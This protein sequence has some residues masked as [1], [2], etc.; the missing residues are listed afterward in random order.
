MAMLRSYLIGATYDWLNDH[1]FTPYILVDTEYD[2]VEV[3]WDFVDDDGKIVL[4]L[5][6]GAIRDFSC[7][8]EGINF[9]A[10]FGGEPMDVFIPIE[11]VLSLYS[12]ESSQGIYAR[13]DVYGLIVNEGDSDV[14][15]D[16]PSLEDKKNTKSSKT[17]G[18]LRLV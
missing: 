7:S 11:S 5:S 8:G 9:R 3:P 4:N 17:K 2:D 16:P 6:P 13:E 1:G 10:S 12:Q 14:E 18:G 15:I